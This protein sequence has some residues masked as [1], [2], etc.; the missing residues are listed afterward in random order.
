MIPWPDAVKCTFLELA[1]VAYVYNL[2]TQKD[3]AGGF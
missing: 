3:E 2:S 1:M